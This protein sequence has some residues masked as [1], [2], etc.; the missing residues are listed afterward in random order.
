M[1]NSYFDL[2][3]QSYYFPQDGFD[4]MDEYLT[5]HGLSLKYLINKYETPFKLVYL[6]RIGEQIKRARNLFNRAIKAYNYKGRY[7]FCYCCSFDHHHHVVPCEE[8]TVY[9]EPLSGIHKSDR[10]GGLFT[11]IAEE[12]VPG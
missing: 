12:E 5:F 11:H 6:P 3:E 8:H 10:R 1:K 9:T 7:Y 2:I 4:L